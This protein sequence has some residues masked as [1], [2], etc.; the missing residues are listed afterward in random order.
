MSPDLERLIQLQQLASTIEE[1]RQRIDAHPERLADAGVR[2]AEATRHVDAAKERLKVSQ[3]SRRELEKEAAVFQGRVSKFKGQ[4]S[5]VKTNREYQAMQHET[6]TAEQELGAVEEKVLEQMMDADAIT[7]DIATAEAAFATQ[8]TEVTAEKAA[9]EQE[10]VVVQATMA[11][12]SQ[13]RETL[14]VEM[15]PRLVALFEQVANVRKGIAI[16]STRDGLCS[17][18]H[19]RLR[20]QVFQ[21]VRANDHIVQCDYCNRIL[22]YIPPPPSAEPAATPAT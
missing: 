14:L 22:Y 18:C 8:K 4:L 1:A 2:L 6:A 5:A 7:A 21:Q 19:V 20:P 16:C 11:E 3:D 9:L 15:E 10:L 12:A 13:A 17:V